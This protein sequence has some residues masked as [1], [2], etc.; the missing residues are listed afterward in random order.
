MF[1]GRGRQRPTCTQINL[2]E[3][4]SRCTPVRICSAI[5]P[6]PKGPES[7]YSALG[8]WTVQTGEWEHRHCVCLGISVPMGSSWLAADALRVADTL[9][10]CHL[11]MCILSRCFSPF[12]T[13]LPS[14][15]QDPSLTPA[16]RTTECQGRVRN[17]QTHLIK[18]GKSHWPMSARQLSFLSCV[19]HKIYSWAGPQSIL[20]ARR[21]PHYP[22]EM[23]LPLQMMFPISKAICRIGLHSPT[24]CTCM[25]VISTKFEWGLWHQMHQMKDKKENQFNATS[26]LDKC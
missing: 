23:I 1:P 8:H 18:N 26:I 11:A 5:C 22:P 6:C 12:L 24:T 14:P 4:G 9:A 16:P 17:L 10:L 2:K 21:E 20:C 25:L 15:F 3:V 13:T 19:C 7:S